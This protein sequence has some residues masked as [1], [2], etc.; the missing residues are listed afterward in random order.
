MPDWRWGFLV[1]SQQDVRKVERIIEAH[2][3][4]Q[5]VGDPLRPDYAIN[6]NDHL[7][8]LIVVRCSADHLPLTDTE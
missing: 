7:F 3:S 5:D 2:N 4:R 1:R 8:W 6:Y